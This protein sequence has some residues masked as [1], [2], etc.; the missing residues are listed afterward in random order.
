MLVLWALNAGKLDDVRRMLTLPV[1]LSK[2][3]N[4]R[5][6]KILILDWTSCMSSKTRHNSLDNYAKSNLRWRVSSFIQTTSMYKMMTAY[7][8]SQP[9]TPVSVS[10]FWTGRPIR[11]HAAMHSGHEI[12]SLPKNWLW[13]FAT[14]A[15]MTT[16]SAS[17]SSTQQ[18]RVSDTKITVP[19]SLKL[20]SIS[21]IN[22][23]ILAMVE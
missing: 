18:T 7:I 17:R 21:E 3:L 10:T 15:R 2:I 19:N 11:R 1:L 6:C 14:A 12:R 16:H 5:V 20:T 8:S 9:M 22:C 13:H 23:K 4:T